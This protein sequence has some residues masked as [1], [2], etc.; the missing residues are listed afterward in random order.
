[1][2]GCK[3]S[4]IGLLARGARFLLVIKCNLFPLWSE[5]AVELMRR[6][7]DGE[8]RSQ[9]RAFYRVLTEHNNAT[10]CHQCAHQRRHLV[11]NLRP[12]L[13]DMCDNTSTLQVTRLAFVIR[14]ETLLF[15][16]ILTCDMRS[17]CTQPPLSICDILTAM[18]HIHREEIEA[19]QREYVA[20]VAQ[21]LPVEE[22]PELVA[23]YAG[24]VK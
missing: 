19:L 20:T 7:L 15:P 23:R 1:M 4:A 12:Y 5:A 3:T 8:F 22:I 10:E 18:F 17:G 13:L 14:N 6:K 11:R 9:V 2:R 24:I 16:D 21:H